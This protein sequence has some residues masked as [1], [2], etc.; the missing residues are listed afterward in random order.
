MADETQTW[1][2]PSVGL[3][4]ARG[5]GGAFLIN[6]GVLVT[7]IETPS[8]PAVGLRRRVRI[9]VPTEI[10]MGSEMERY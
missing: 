7:Y 9:R 4:C 10:I 6:P 2:V 5:G 8:P 3:A 1:P